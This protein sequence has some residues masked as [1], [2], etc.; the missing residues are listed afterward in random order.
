VGPVTL[1]DVRYIRLAAANVKRMYSLQ[2]RPGGMS[3]GGAR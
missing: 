2:K 3:G 1:D